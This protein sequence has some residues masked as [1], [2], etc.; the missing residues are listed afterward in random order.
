MEQEKEQK[1]EFISP[2]VDVTEK[3]EQQCN[4]IL[5]KNID[6]AESILI[7]MR[8]KLK[9][10]SISYEFIHALLKDVKTSKNVPIVD[11]KDYVDYIEFADHEKSAIILVRLNKEYKRALRILD[12]EKVKKR[13]I[14][15][16][17]CKERVVF[18]EG[19]MKEYKETKC[20]PYVNLGGITNDLFLINTKNTF[21]N[22]LLDLDY[23]YGSI[24][25][26]IKK[27]INIII[28]RIDHYKNSERK[29]TTNN[30]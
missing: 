18:L 2:I 4:E 16:V 14:R 7:Q 24:E 15:Y 28:K 12:K 20:A 29:D 27:Q 19:L 9:T 17:K 30:S 5:N 11:I 13:D 3:S 21:K 1:Q 26:N 23:I 25:D 6:L 10:V 22:V 8:D